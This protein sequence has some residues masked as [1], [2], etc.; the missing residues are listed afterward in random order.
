[1]V[2]GGFEANAGWALGNTARPAM[3][4]TEQQHA[5]ARAMQL[6]S[7]SLSNTQSYSSVSQAVTIPAGTNNVTLRW[8][9]WVGT[10]E[11]TTTAPGTTSDRQEVLLLAPT[12]QVRAV[13]QRTR[14]TSGGW[15]EVTADLNAYRAETVT[16]Y[17]NVYNDGVNGRTWMYIDDVQL[18]CTPS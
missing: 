7:P 11:S 6:G 17:F 9:Q 1:V 13:I 3:Y 8:W 4:T 5:G 18:I 10:E 12:D 14:Q 2:N 16:L 15:Q